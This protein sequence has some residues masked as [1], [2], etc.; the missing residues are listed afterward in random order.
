MLGLATKVLHLP[1]RL[2]AWLDLLQAYDGGSA[3]LERL[4]W[5]LLMHCHF[6]M[7]RSVQAKI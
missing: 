6:R 5:Q 2:T 3:L 7:D 1:Q 4:C